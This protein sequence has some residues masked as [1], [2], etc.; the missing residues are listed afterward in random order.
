MPANFTSGWLGN[1][2][3][4]WHGQGVVTEGTLPAREAFETADALFEVEKRELQFPT[5]S[6]V[7]A[8]EANCWSNTPAGVF[9][10]VRTDTQALLGVVSKQY[11]IVQNDSLLRMAEFIR[12]EADMDSVVVLADGA[13]VCFTATLR[14]A[15]TDIVPGDT[16]K[17]RL[18]GYLGHDG[19]TGCGAIF[20]NVRV[21]CCNTLAA[22][23][24]S[25]NKVS[26]H[27]KSG[28]N[29]SF[30][31]LISSI[32]V[33]RQTFAQEADLMREF[34][35]VSMGHTVFNEYLDEVYQIEEGQKFRKRDKLNRAFRHGLGA[36]YA[37]MSL[38]NA[39]NAVTEIETST[40]NQTAA[41]ARRQF[42]RANFGVGRQM[43]SRAIEVATAYLSAV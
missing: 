7:G 14:G 40:R 17:R 21:V 8:N 28:A 12:E 24:N 31:A 23:L 35:R 2:E 10:V 33:A 13:K 30:D 36:D 1:G 25:K 29:A 3:A 6:V 43:S 4:A 32:D 34:T 20:T 15:E 37:P 26:V 22:A 39:V 42:A 27:H 5:Y 19:K 18:V 16:I 11:E 38:W 41:G 9:G